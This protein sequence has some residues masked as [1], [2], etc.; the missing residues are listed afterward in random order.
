MQ[1]NSGKIALISAAEFAQ[2]FTV[3]RYILDS[4]ITCLLRDQGAGNAGSEKAFSSGH[5]SR[6]YMLTCLLRH[7]SINLHLKSFHFPPS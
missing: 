6:L 5:N 4:T 7:T 2:L 3:V 1:T